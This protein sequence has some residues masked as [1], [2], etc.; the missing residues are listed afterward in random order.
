MVDVEAQE[1]P[2]EGMK[3]IID[4]TDLDSYGGETVDEK[5]DSLIAAHPVVLISKTWCP[6]SRD[7]KDL[8]GTQIGVEVYSLEVN[9]HPQGGA[10]FKYV[11]DK[12]EHH[13][14][15]MVFI[16][17]EFIGGCDDTKALYKS[18]ELER[19]YLKGL[20][21]RK[22][23]KDTETLETAKLIPKE[24][25]TAMN[26]P[27]WFPNQ[28]NNLVV[29]CVGLQVF[30][31][32]AISTAFYY[33]IWGRYLA[34]GLL[35]DF[36]IRLVAGSSLS[37]LGMNATFITSF[38]KPDFR[39]GPPKQFAAFC[40]LFFSLLG[41]LF[42]FL[43][44]D[45]HDIVGAIWMAML[46]FAAGLEG[47]LD[48]CLG[49]LFYGFGIQFGLIPDSVYRIYTASRQEIVESWDYKFGDSNGTYQ[50]C[51]IQLDWI[52][53]HRFV[54]GSSKIYSASSDTRRYRSKFRRG[55]QVPEE[56]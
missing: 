28:V 45:G 29:R 8:L 44:F 33:K 39:P 26:P 30:C 5:A 37:P 36:A 15:P 6:F 49:C 14:V 23:T 47:F 48:F 52:R 31:L 53:S 35:V 19:T 13:T 12:Y 18:G 16:K 42:Y 50:I 54:F 1:A 34:V 27:L 46:A 20:I 22:Q 21:G 7:A 32:S 41:T 17:G 10:V 11:S 25:S 4:V 55:P 2:A 51:C 9:T 24:R 40:G 43:T 56:D 38:F 3:N